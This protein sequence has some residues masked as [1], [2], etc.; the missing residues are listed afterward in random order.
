MEKSQL[1]IELPKGTNPRPGTVPRGR[2]SSIGCGLTLIPQSDFSSTFWWSGW[3]NRW[4]WQWWLVTWETDCSIHDTALDN[5]FLILDGAVLGGG[6][7][8]WGMA[9]WDNFCAEIFFRAA[10]AR[11][12]LISILCF[13]LL[14]L[15]TLSYLFFSCNWYWAWL[16]AAAGGGSGHRA[17]LSVLSCW[18]SAGQFKTDK[19]DTWS[20]KQKMF[21]MYCLNDQA[22]IA[23][24]TS[25]QEV[26]VKLAVQLT[27]IFIQDWKESPSILVN[28]CEVCSSVF[29]H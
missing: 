8:C 10:A 17:L 23:W 25:I 7:G 3:G 12:P 1:T 4:W 24:F 27:V 5:W 20:W 13:R 14:L 2:A 28:S 18:R 9:V 16:P 29:P 26:C 21:W 15:D 6:G 11:Y 22:L 19:L